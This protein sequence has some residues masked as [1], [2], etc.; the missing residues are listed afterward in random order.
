MLKQKLI[1]ALK[2]AGLN[3]GLA[4]FITITEESQVEGVISS[5]QSTQN[6][7]SVTPDYEKIVGSEGFG[8]WVKEKG[9][10]KVIE[11]SKSLKSG[12]DSMVTQGV[13]TF[14]D[15]HFKQITDGNAGKEGNAQKT[16]DPVL[17]ALQKISQRIDGLEQ[18]KTTESKKEQAKKAI[19]ES[20]S[21]PDTVKEKWLS[22]IDLESETSFEE[23]VKGL[24]T[25][26]TEIHTGI[27]GSSSGKGL[28]LGVGSTGE[29]SDEEANDVVDSIV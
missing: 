28:P 13:K 23:Q 14:S 12:A 11:I 5:L 7:D 20:K 19:S 2:K 6:P 27:V 21:L 4:D 29:V 24:E 3:E 17:D 22:R 18:S 26:Y 10:T 1:E 15:K 8:Q 9:F 25:E 16:D